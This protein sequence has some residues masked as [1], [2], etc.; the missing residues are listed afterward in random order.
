M[1]EHFLEHELKTILRIWFSKVLVHAKLE[2]CW[3]TGK[4]IAGA[5]HEDGDI[6]GTLNLFYFLQHVYAAHSRHVDVEENVVGPGLRQNMQGIFAIRSRNHFNARVILRQLL[7]ED[8]LVFIVVPVVLSVVSLV[9]VWLPARRATQID[10]VIAL[11][12]E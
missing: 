5:I 10:P 11:R 4:P 12:A 3:F 7:D 8:L 1:V 2:C 9:A 6:S